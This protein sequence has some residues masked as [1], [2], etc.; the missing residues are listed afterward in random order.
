[1]LSSNGLVLGGVN[2]IDLDAT[3]VSHAVLY[4]ATRRCLFHDSETG[5]LSCTVSDVSEYYTSDMVILANRM[6]DCVRATES[7][8][9]VEG[10]SP[11]QEF[12]FIA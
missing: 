7:K 9:G 6:S 1:M 4:R 3:E 2:P 12:R 10:S 8:F 11:P 5:V